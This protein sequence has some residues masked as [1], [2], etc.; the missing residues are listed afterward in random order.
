MKSPEEI[1]QFLSM[2]PIIFENIETNQSY[3][4]NILIFKRNFKKITEYLNVTLSFIKNLYNMIDI[5]NIVLTVLSNI[6]TVKTVLFV[7]STLII[8]NSITQSIGTR[9]YRILR[10]DEYKIKITLDNSG[11]TPWNVDN[12]IVC[13]KDL[14]GIIVYPTIVTNNNEINIYF[15]DIIGSNYKVILL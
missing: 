12:I 8:N 7:D 13:V 5:N 1:Q 11:T 3:K 4:T 2:N 9:I 15:N 6:E 10:I 14:N